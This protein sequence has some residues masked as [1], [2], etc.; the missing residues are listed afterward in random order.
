MNSRP[1]LVHR[2]DQSSHQL[3]D[4]VFEPGETKPAKPVKEKKKKAKRSFAETGLDVRNS[5]HAPNL[6]KRRNPRHRRD[7]WLL[8]T[9]L[10]I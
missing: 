2:A 1:F 4:D 10:L 8:L 5:E 9:S 3:P 7:T 6:T